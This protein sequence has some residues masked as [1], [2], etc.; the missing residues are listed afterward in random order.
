MSACMAFLYVKFC[1]QTVFVGVLN[2]FLKTREDGEI[3][4]VNESI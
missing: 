1:L 2:A 3:K 4:L